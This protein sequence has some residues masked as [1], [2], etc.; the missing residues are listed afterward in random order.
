VIGRGLARNPFAAAR[1]APGAVPWVGDDAAEV[2]RLFDRAARPGARHQVLGPHGSGKS[3]LL[4]HLAAHGRRA[5]ARVLAFRGSAG[6]PSA[7]LARLGAAHGTRVVLVDEVE[8]LGAATRALLVPFARVAR[9][10]LVASTHRDLGWPTLCERRVD[11]AL[12][13]RVVEHLVAGSGEPLR[14]EADI[15]PRLARHAGN[16]REVLFELYD[17]AEARARRA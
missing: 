8:E 5:G 17:E 12:C 6:V 16:V 14:T 13:A 11:A 15:A 3:T 1:F 4:A 10:A 2:A 7:A 9:I